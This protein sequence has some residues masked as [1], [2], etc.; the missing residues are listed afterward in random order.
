MVFSDTDEYLLVLTVSGRVDG[1][2]TDTAEQVFSIDRCF[3]V[4]DSGLIDWFTAV[5]DPANSRLILTAANESGKTGDLDFYRSKY[6]TTVLDTPSWE[7]TAQ[8]DDVCCWSPKHKKVYIV[9]GGQRGI[10]KA[11][12]LADLMLQAR[13]M[14][15]AQ[16]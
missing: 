4:S 7:I 12:S 8:P 5:S 14:L 9:S 11:H 13:K 15:N 6:W 16:Q 1:F 2:R 3:A 10:C